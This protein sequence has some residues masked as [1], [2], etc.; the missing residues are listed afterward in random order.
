MATAKKAVAKKAGA[1]R[2]AAP[3]AET[4]HDRVDGALCTCTQFH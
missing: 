4:R 1:K 3:V 2:A